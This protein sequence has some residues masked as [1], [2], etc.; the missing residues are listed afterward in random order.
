MLSALLA[1]VFLC[2]VSGEASAQTRKLKLYFLHTGERAEITYKKNGRYVQSGL[3]KINRF[4]RDWRRNE[5]TKMDPRLLDLV[6]EIYKESGSRKHI[7]VISAYRS[8][9]TNSLLRKRGRGVAKKSQHTLGKAMDFFIP[10]VSLRKLRYIG[11]RKGLGG[12]GY[13]PKSG[14]PFVHMDTGRVRHWPRMSRK[15]LVRVFP[16]GKTLHVPS[17]GKP[18]ARYNQ[19]KAEYER[20]IKGGSKIVIARAE[21]IEKKPGLFAKWLGRGEEEEGQLGVVSA[22]KPVAVKKQEAPKP[23]QEEKVVT[24]VADTPKPEDVVPEEPQPQPV[25]TPEIILS[26]LPSDL[27]PVPLAAPRAVPEEPEP[28]IVVPDEPVPETVVAET[29]VT[30]AEVAE[31]VVA[32]TVVTEAEV[33]KKAAAETIVAEAEVAETAVAETIVAEA[34]VGDTVVAKIVPPEGLET[35]PPPAEVEIAETVVVDP[36]PPK[37]L[38]TE[39]TLAEQLDAGDTTGETIELA[40]GIPLPAQRPE[41]SPIESVI[42]AAGSETALE[43]PAP[44]EPIRVAAL[45]PVEI[46]DLRAQVYSV[47]ESG[48]E[49][50]TGETVEIRPPEPIP[51]VETVATVAASVK[52]PIDGGVIVSSAR[53]RENGNTLSLYPQPNPKKIAALA[54]E[55]R[56]AALTP[57]EPGAN[58]RNQP[59]VPSIRP[60]FEKPAVEVAILEPLEPGSR[61]TDK[62][63]LP[64]PNPDRKVASEDAQIEIATAPNVPVPVPAVRLALAA[65]EEPPISSDKP[66]IESRLSALASSAST[67]RTLGK[68]ALAADTLIERIGDIRPPAYAKNIIRERPSTVLSQ[69]FVSNGG[70]LTT[71]S[72]S[73]SSVEFLDFTRF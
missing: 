73:G 52:P 1:V 4:L 36:L 17:D 29:V 15:E 22:P 49:N 18:L 64:S 19:A 26:S 60:V 16:K 38:E 12:V 70:D 9:A 44:A 34:E 47:L 10:G 48:G 21:E 55:E 53:A 13:Y 27:V 67:E 20:K 65:A 7:H 40:Y 25:A 32:E 24:P 39:P 6:W 23:A 50:S 68:W 62:T 69:G 57:L 14:S 71:A 63:P 37:R 2:L 43:R 51:Q 8:P 59:A 54:I 11:L 33:G 58:T 28:E 30:E 46:E 61:S 66:T 42:A 35:E 72:F 41:L 31:T 3:K 5:P 56:L 45:S